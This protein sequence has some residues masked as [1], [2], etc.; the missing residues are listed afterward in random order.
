[1]DGE[2]MKKRGEPSHLNINFDKYNFLIAY[3]FNYI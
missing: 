1:M 3:Y 2:M